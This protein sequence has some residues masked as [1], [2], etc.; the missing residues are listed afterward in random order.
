M[1]AGRPAL[2]FEGN[3]EAAVPASDREDIPAGV[4]RAGSSPGEN[5]K[6]EIIRGKVAEG[7]VGIP[8]FAL[9]RRSVEICCRTC[10]GRVEGSVAGGG[11]AAIDVGNEV[12]GVSGGILRFVGS[13]F[14]TTRLAEM[15]RGVGDDGCVGRRQ[16]QER[17]EEG[18]RDQVW[19]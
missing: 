19:D 4:A 6:R 9:S 14:E 7:S 11:A 16:G 2:A 5:A 13:G 1:A 17:G 18:V 8:A 12:P 10:R 3:L 15:I